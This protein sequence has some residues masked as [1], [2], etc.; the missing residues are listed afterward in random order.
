MR[1]FKHLSASQDDEIMSELI[2][3][4]G[5]AGYGIWW[6][7]LEKIALSCGENDETTARYSAKR[8]SN[9]AGCSAQYFRKVARFLDARIPNF[10]IDDDGRYIK[11]DCPNILKYRDEYTQ[12]KK[13]K[14]AND[15]GHSP[16]AG[17]GCTPDNV[18][19]EQT[20]TQT[21]STEGEQ[22][23]EEDSPFAEG[24]TSQEN[25]PYVCAI[26]TNRQDKP[27]RIKQSQANKWQ[28]Q[29]RFVDVYGE[30][31]RLE[32]YFK[33]DGQ[34]QPWNHK[35]AFMALSQAL[36]KANQRE[37]HRYHQ[38]DPTFDPVDPDGSKKAE[39]DWQ[40]TQQKIKKLADSKAIGGNA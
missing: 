15:S 32:E 33:N 18:L 8:W 10:C 25:D 13:R 36:N 19:R 34:A 23:T 40:A 31:G 3:E 22:S 6:I 38:R 27:L 35:G 20:Q 7:I 9:F 4:F 28:Q 11:I 21:Q 1:W 29:F 39:A 26:P 5:P 12:K 30:M 24:R 37:M 17:S 16:D 14:Q 2:D